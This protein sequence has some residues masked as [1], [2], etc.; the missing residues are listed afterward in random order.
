MNDQWKLRP[1]IGVQ[2]PPSESTE[3][4]PDSSR[5]P[6]VQITMVTLTDTELSLRG[7]SVNA[8]WSGAGRRHDNLSPERIFWQ[9]QCV[10][11]ACIDE[12]ADGWITASQGYLARCD[13]AGDGIARSFLHTHPDGAERPLT[14]KGCL[15]MLTGASYKRT[16]SLSA[17]TSNSVNNLPHTTHFTMTHSII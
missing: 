8:G 6:R 12:E 14:F 13:S 15:E 17:H 2:P 3:P 11:G 5:P 9:P 1:L 4:K 7:W 16:C 10:A